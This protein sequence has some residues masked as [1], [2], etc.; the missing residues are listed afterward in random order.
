MVVN[1]SAELRRSRVRVQREREAAAI[2]QSTLFDPPSEDTAPRRRSGPPC[3]SRE[4][5]AAISGTVA[6][7]KQRI[8]AWLRAQNM[9][10]TSL[11]IAARAQ[12]ERH[13]VASRLRELEQGDLVKRRG[14]RICEIGGR[15]AITWEVAQ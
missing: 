11:E 3:T 7:Q 1:R 8:L 6:G 15:R 9:P 10:L 13:A 14:T 12:I 2:G 5:Y 4:A